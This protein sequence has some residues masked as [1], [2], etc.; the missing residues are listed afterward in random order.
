MDELTTCQERG[1]AFLEDFE[2]GRLGAAAA[3]E[4]AAGVGKTWLVAHWLERLCERHSDGEGGWR[5]TLPAVTVTAYTNKAVD[6]LRAKVGHLPIQ[7]KT[8]DSF[9]GY[10]V[11]KNDDGVVERSRFKNN[12]DPDIIVVDEAS[13]VPVDYVHELASR[14]TYHKGKLQPLPVLYVGDK[15]QLAPVG[16]KTSTALDGPAHQCEMTTPTRQ[17][18]GSPI[19]QL[20]THLRECVESGRMFILPDLRKYADNKAVTFTPRTNVVNWALA[21]I[22]KGMDTRVLAWDNNSVNRYN[23]DMHRSLYPDAAVFGAGER[24]LVN[25]AFEVNDD[26]MLLNGELLDVL[27][28]EPDGVEA[29]NV[30]CWRVLVQAPHLSPLELRVAQDPHLLAVRHKQLTEQLWAARRAGN[31]AEA[32]RLVQAR[33]PLN[34]LAP[35]RHSYASTVHKAQGSTYDVALVDFSSVYRSDERARLMYVAT[36]RPSQFLVL[37]H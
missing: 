16:E 9:L 34:K 4:G 6:V 19:I 5:D 32:D 15:F 11:K 30:A 10:K 13:M 28:C 8:L 26:V 35:L 27:T 17:A 20:A 1:L 14:G 29:G 23:A 37:G 12:K 36:T 33:K 3:L 24:V 31:I 21:A 22:R 7:F 25:E 18:L 2:A